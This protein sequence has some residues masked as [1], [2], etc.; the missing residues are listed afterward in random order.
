MPARKSTAEDE[1][2]A[3]QGE[4]ERR[5]RRKRRQ[6]REGEAAAPTA[7]GRGGAPSAGEARAH[8]V[9]QLPRRLL[10]GGAAAACVGLA[11]V[12]TG[13]SVVGPWVCLA[14]LL[15]LIYGVHSHG[16]LGPG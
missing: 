14:A 8:L 13:P 15:A 2:E 1:A 5:P 3:G 10:I 16:R 6:P 4:G 12:G 9:E 11:M 7:P